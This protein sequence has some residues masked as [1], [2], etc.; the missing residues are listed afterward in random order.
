MKI[1]RDWKYVVARAWS[2]KFAVLTAISGTFPLFV[3]SI[4]PLW[5]ASLTTMLAILTAIVRIIDQP[6]MDR[7]KES[8]LVTEDRRK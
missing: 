5:F 4:S 8:I 3:S 1:S 6:N 2:M 7:R